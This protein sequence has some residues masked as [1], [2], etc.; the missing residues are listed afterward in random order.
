MT[1]HRV[2]PASLTRMHLNPFLLA[3]ACLLF[4]ALTVS[5]EEP[6][7]RELLRDG[8]YAEE[9]TRD[10]EAAAKQYEQVL[11]RYSEQRDFAAAAL[12]RLAE[13]RR[14]QD[15]KDDAIKL[16]QRLL[17]EFPGAAAEGKLAAENL[18]ALGGNIPAPTAVA[19][20][21]ESRELARLTSLAKT[22]PDI[23]LDPATLHLAAQSGWS[24]VVDHLLA[25]G[26][27]PYSG[28]A[29]LIAVERGY[30]EIVRQLTAGDTRPPESLAASAVRQAIASD[31]YTILEYLLQQG[32][33][34]A[35]L[36]GLFCEALLMKKQP[37]AE[38]LL[39]HGAS[40]DAMSQTQNFPGQ[41]DENRALQERIAANDFE[42]ANWLLKKGAKPDLANSQGITPLHYAAWGQTD[43][44]LAMMEKLLAAGA[45]PNSATAYRNIGGTIRDFALVDAT[46]LK[47]AMLSQF[48]AAEKM[49]L[50]L[51]HGADPN[52]KGSQG[53]SIISQVFKNDRNDV[54]E[55][56]QL[57]LKS[58]ASASEPGLIETAIKNDD[59]KSLALLLKD[60]AGPNSLGTKGKPLLANACEKGD[61]AL[62][63][64]L[65]EAG[66][67]PNL[68]FGEV[69]LNRE[70][71][72]ADP[73]AA[74]TG[75]YEKYSD[76]FL[77]TVSHKDPQR[78]RE[79][80]RLLL[81]AGAKPG[82]DLG[83]LLR[84]VAEFDEDGSLTRKLLTPRPEVN[85]LT[86]FRYEMDAWLEA[87]RRI[88]LDEL[89]FPVLAKRPG[90]H[91]VDNTSGKWSTIADPGVDQ[92]LPKTVDLLMGKRDALLPIRVESRNPNPDKI[93]PQPQY[94]A[95]YWPQLTLVRN[96]NDGKPSREPIIWESDKPFPELR[97]GDILELGKEGKAMDENEASGTKSKL[98]WHLR[99]RVVVSVTVEI[100]GKS[101][102]IS[103]RGDRLFFDPTKDE[104]PLATAQ[105]VVDFLLQPGGYRPMERGMF[106]DGK[107]VDKIV[108]RNLLVISRP[109]WPDI[110]LESGSLAAAKFQL[111]SGDDL[112]VEISEDYRIGLRQHRERNV[113]IQVPGFP[114]ALGLTN[115]GESPKSAAQLPSLI[116]ALVETQI[117]RNPSWRDLDGTEQVF[118]RQ[119]F[120]QFTILPHPDLSR[121]RIRRLLEDGKET[122]IDVDLQKAISATTV[123]TSADE[124]RKDDVILQ[125][126]DVIEIPLR[127]DDLELPWKG[128]SADA[129]RFFSKALS[130]RVQVTDGAGIVTVREL[131]YRAPGFVPS[132]GVWIPVPAGSGVPGVGIWRVLGGS[133]GTLK[134][135]DIETT[136]VGSVFLRDG[137]VFRA[138][139]RRGTRVVPPPTPQQPSS[140]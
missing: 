30:L 7:L 20:D 88:I 123:E 101:R 17:A 83:Y 2:K 23:L 49:Q 97:H 56:L 93:Q 62:V 15:R 78:K 31:R 65:L 9:V 96:S 13:V 58:G 32:I 111:E 69:L 137:D 42:A 98:D 70:E 52:W 125:V 67:D 5:A 100:D 103:L 40:P 51:K 135:G 57:L 35:S 109:G 48:K 26:S 84:Q 71:G 128:F 66:A 16:Y 29:L 54:P 53:N 46:P 41:L 132:A 8:L 119:A 126:G 72:H 139:I 37:S 112:K 92:P 43:A 99:K 130:G 116:Q 79:I 86:A 133:P 14:K 39:K 118:P 127:K 10:S 55:L 61:V 108:T 19:G 47:T 94:N 50:L 34:P 28:K 138:D 33:K 63:K 75:K 6:P 77:N 110:R 21:D 24:R 115:F 59:S 44:S 11:T 64:T 1:I 25:A 12:F 85:N 106:I 80:L 114:Y 122:V 4:P 90:V 22:A 102:A 113:T 117:P 45:N 134:R 104:M 136:D 120:D 76:N 87:P 131:E 124:A 27:Q 73:F 140:R 105:Q 74:T 91:L 18:A 3:A 129:Q 68:P 38:L 81:N 107:V 121:I 89:L 60:G 95:I 36:D 82:A